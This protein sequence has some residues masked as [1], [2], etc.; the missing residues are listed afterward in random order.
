MNSLFN[1]ESSTMRFLEKAANLMLLNLLWILCSL[2]I[3]TIGASSTALYTMVFKLLNSE[4]ES[5]NII[6]PFFS[7][8]RKEFWKSE[9]IYGI[10]LVLALIVTANAFGSQRLP[11]PL[12]ICA[13]VPFFI[14][15]IALGYIFPLYSKFENNYVNTLKN[16]V[17]LSLI[18]FPKSILILCSNL[19]PVIVLLLSEALFWKLFVFWILI[20][21]ALS[22]YF[23]AKWLTPI[24]DKM[25]LSTKAD[26]NANSI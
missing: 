2:P 21:F 23:V 12:S 5:I 9:G 1:P 25:I 8:F 11:T 14:F 16:A 20:Y 18:H 13:L 17:L 7:V 3:I 6:K 24:F 26:E 10:T 4:N 15:C 22:A 19:L